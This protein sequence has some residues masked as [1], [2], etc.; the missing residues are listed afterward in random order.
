MRTKRFTLIELLVV[1]AI[2]AIL[3]AMLLPALSK[4]RDKAKTISCSSKMKQYGL[5]LA[6]Y[7]GDNDDNLPPIM[8]LWHGENPRSL[9]GHFVNVAWF[10]R[11][12][13]SRDKNYKWLVKG[14]NAMCCP[15]DTQPWSSGK[16]HLARMSYYGNTCAMGTYD[17]MASYEDGTS[18]WNRPNRTNPTYTSYGPLLG[19]L[20]NNT[21]N[22]PVSRIDVLFCAPKPE[23]RADLAYTYGYSDFGNLKNASETQYNNLTAIH[24]TGTNWLFWDGHVQHLNFLRFEAPAATLFRN[25]SSLRKYWNW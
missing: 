6:M 12:Y 18:V 23:A 25:G 16:N 17:S 4:A 14:K 15:A 2:I 24:K 9:E 5:D 22:K 3:A 7:E 20:K 11:F 19:T 1:I 8:E 21:A 13:A 10:H